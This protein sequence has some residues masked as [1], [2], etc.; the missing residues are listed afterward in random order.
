MR[1]KVARILRRT[2]RA[3]TP[4]KNYKQQY[5]T[6]KR[7]WN[8]APRNTRGLIRLRLEKIIEEHNKK[9]LINNKLNK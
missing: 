4:D 5:K 6:V 7:N 8:D 2:S 9:E 3:T 1:N